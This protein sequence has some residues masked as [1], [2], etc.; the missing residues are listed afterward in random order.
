MNLHRFWFK[1]SPVP[2]HNSLRSG[3]GVTAY[4]YDDAIEILTKT[5]F[6]D[7]EFPGLFSFIKDIDISTLDQNHVIPNMEP[8]VRRG[9]WFPKGFT[10]I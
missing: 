9:V 10:K 2:T 4:S 6:L 1:F 7:Q 3:C 5:V 8:P